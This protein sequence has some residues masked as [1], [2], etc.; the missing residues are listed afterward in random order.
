MSSIITAVF[1]LTVGLLVN[2]GT[3]IR[4]RRN[5]KMAT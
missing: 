4:Q 1:K 2:K 3:D 5:L